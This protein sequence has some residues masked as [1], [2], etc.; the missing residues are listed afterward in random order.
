MKST[1]IAYRINATHCRFNNKSSTWHTKSGK[2]GE[3]FLLIF[4]NAC[5]MIPTEN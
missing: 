4:T 5:A 2:G 1:F 3:K